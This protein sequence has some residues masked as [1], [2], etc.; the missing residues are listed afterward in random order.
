MLNKQPSSTDILELCEKGHNFQRNL[1]K[2]LS[3]RIIYLNRKVKMLS[4][5]TI[6]QRLSCYLL[7]E[8][9]KQKSLDLKCRHTRSDIA[10]LIGSTRP[11]I[12]R[13]LSNMQRQGIIKLTPKG[14]TVLDKHALETTNK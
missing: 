7:D 3:E 2:S 14:I 1:I 8:S 4:H 5:R 6:R 12:S 10:D 9:Q 11:S 13:E